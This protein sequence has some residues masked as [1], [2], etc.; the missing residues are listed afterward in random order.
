MYY[1]IFEPPL[2]A[3]EYERT[4]QIKEM[5]SSLGIAG[6]MTNPTPGRTVE[7]LVQLAVAKRYSTIVAVGG[8]ELINRVARALEPYDVVFGIIPFAEDRDITKLIGVS[9]PRSAAEH[10]KRRRWQEVRLGLMNSELCF[11]TP[12]TIAIPDNVF[13]SLATP[14]Y[15]AEGQGGTITI[16][17]LRGEQEGQG[18]FT[19]EVGRNSSEKSGLLK[20]LFGKKK[21]QFFESKFSIPY[22]EL[23]TQSNLPVVVAGTTVCTTPIRCETQEKP[24]K[25]IIAKGTLAS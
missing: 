12:A 18:G 19:V 5:L 20:S 22:F 15:S 2:E 1:Y 16:T 24:I 17:P 4:A 6:E 11:I 21:D 3:K 25:L 9:D 8:I 10:L 14:T 7:D 23:S 13:Y